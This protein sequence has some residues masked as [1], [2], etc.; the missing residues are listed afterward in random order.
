M[1]E[2]ERPTFPPPFLIRSGLGT[3]CRRGAAIAE[4]VGTVVFVAAAEAVVPHARGVLLARDLLP[5]VLVKYV[6]LGIHVVLG[7]MLLG[8]LSE[9]LAVRWC[10]RHDY[11]T[12][13]RAEKERK[14][15]EGRK[16]SA[17]IRS[18]GGAVIGLLV[19]I[20]LAMTNPSQDRHEQI[21]KDTVVQ[22]RSVEEVVD[23]AAKAVPR[24]KYHSLLVFSWTTMDDE[25]ISFGVL[26]FVWAN[27]IAV[28]AR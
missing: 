22:D 16:L 14:A 3:T 28:T 21:I 15:R 4:M 19:L 1:A 27:E 13:L 25:L 23:V 18:V 17:V 12:V 11:W 24:P 6:V 8:A 26:G 9:F 2:N 10:D 20:V 5:P 7:I